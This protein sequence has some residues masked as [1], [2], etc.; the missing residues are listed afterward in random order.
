[1]V[2]PKLRE[3]AA[4]YNVTP[5]LTTVNSEVHGH[6]TFPE[7]SSAEIFNKL[8]DEKTE[9]N[10]KSMTDRYPVSKLLGVFYLRE[11]AERTSKS[12]QPFVIINFLNPGLC[13]SELSRDSGFFLEIMKFLFARTTEVGSRTLVN[14]TTAGEASHGQYLSSCA[15]ASYVDPPDRRWLRRG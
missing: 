1:M 6:T 11:L 7:K 4:K 14:A 8:N 9:N 10:K 12:G 2:L 13:H 15:I 5:Y 3:T